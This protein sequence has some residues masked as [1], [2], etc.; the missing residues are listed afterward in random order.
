LTP[1]TSWE[2]ELRIPFD[3]KINNPHVTNIKENLIAGIIHRGMSKST[4][5]FEY[6]NRDNN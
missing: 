3:V 1:F 6:S 2:S 5:N 4:L